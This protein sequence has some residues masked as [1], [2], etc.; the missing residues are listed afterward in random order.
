MAYQYATPPEDV[1]LFNFVK[2]AMSNV[3]DFQRVHDIRPKC[4]EMGWGVVDDL[5][6]FELPKAHE[7]MS[8]L[9]ARPEVTKEVAIDTLRRLANEEAWEKTIPR[10][11]VQAWLKRVTTVAGATP[12]PGVGVG[13]CYGCRQK[14]KLYRLQCRACKARALAVAPERLVGTDTIAVHVGFRRSWSTLF[15]FPKFE[16]K[17]VDYPGAKSF[18]T[19]IVSWLIVNRNQKIMSYEAFCRWYKRQDIVTTPRATLC[20]PM[21]NHC[22]PITYPRGAPV[23]AAAF[24]VRLGSLSLHVPS[25]LVYDLAFQLTKPHI[26]RLTP[27]S[28]RAFL[29][30]YSAAKRAKM[31]EAYRMECEG[32]LDV[33][34]HVEAV[35]TQYGIFDQTV[36]RVRMGGFTKQENGYDAEYDMDYSWTLK[37]TM[38]PRFICS[39]EPIILMKLGPYTHSQT[40]WLA[41]TFRCTHR[42]FYAGCATPSEMN[43]WLNF[44]HTE[45]G[46]FI[47]IVDDIT[48]IDSNH[49]FESFEYHERVRNLQ[50]PDLPRLIELLYS[51]EMVFKVRI[52]TLMAYVSFVN[53]SGV[54]DTSYKNSLICLFIRAIAVASA[55]YG[56][57]SLIA[58]PDAAECV[59]RV[60][61][62]TYQAASGDDGI[63]RCPRYICGV[64]I[65]TTQALEEYRAAW[66]AAGFSVKVK[67][68]PEHRWRMG[69]F[70]AQRPVW[71]GSEYEWA[72]E[73]ARRMRKMFW[74]LDS[75]LHPFS[76]GR[77]VAT[78]VLQQGRCC[79]PLAIVCEWYLSRT[80][81]PVAAL[82]VEQH[83]P[84][85]GHRSTGFIDERT[86]SEFYV[87]YRV[88]AHD[89]H[90]FKT[91]LNNSPT[92]TIDISCHLLDRILCEES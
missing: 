78:Q 86:L 79:V 46:G 33:T 53:A 22:E 28:T 13:C 52:G 44:T 72:P 45:L 70:L 11:E 82:E 41:H 39:P 15:T 9:A 6:G 55:V 31:E 90:V 54:S 73:P 91:L 16:F 63:V 56:Y 17:T 20:G 68:L 75:S 59:N 77:G 34:E 37:S 8:R 89:V 7:L 24:C 67:C 92:V 87:D 32:W 5:V 25:R 60:L 23:A 19:K 30:N 51:G 84:M 76:W 80:S 21:F 62:C 38:K 81:G 4:P 40:K 27:D 71:N 10:E 58:R 12:Q 35:Y 36:L 74:Q 43:R 26:L 3:L 42:M 29:S 48:A 2:S 83:N 1:T 61:Q 65:T 66:A 14:A 47:T 69:T 85:A 18:K 88:D 57:K 64:D 50:F 49:S